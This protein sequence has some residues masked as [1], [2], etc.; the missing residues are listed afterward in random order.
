MIFASM[1]LNK[2][3]YHETEEETEETADHRGGLYARQPQGGKARRDCRA[4]EAGFNENGA[5]QV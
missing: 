5:P 2:Q 1:R 3:V 4:W